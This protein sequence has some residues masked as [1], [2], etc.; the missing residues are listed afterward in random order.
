MWGNMKADVRLPGIE[1]ALSLRPNLTASG[2]TTY[3]LPHYLFRLPHYLF[4]TSLSSLPI[5]HYIFF[6]AYSSLPF[7]ITYSSLPI[8]HY[9]FR[10]A[11]Y[12]LRQPQ[13]DTPNPEP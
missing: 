1:R 3:S 12:L 2:L 11:N 6:T 9:L 5:P 13:V 10:L 7:L 8:P 4:L